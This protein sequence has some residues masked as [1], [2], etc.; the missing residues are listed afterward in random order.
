MKKFG[1]VLGGLITLFGLGIILT[2]LR[3]YFIIGSIV[4]FVLIINGI[5]T[6]VGGLKSKSRSKSISG[7]V[8]TAIA[9]FLLFTE[10]QQTLTE[11]F[12]IY[13]VAGGIMLTGLIETV[14]GLILLKKKENGLTTFLMGVGSL[15][16]GLAGIIFKET[17]AMV[18]G[19]VVGYHIVRFGLN[20]FT[21]ARD[22]D[23]PQVIDLKEQVIKRD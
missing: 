12:I 16:V 20:I 23:K 6:L 21:F 19:A 10:M 8:T 3:T 5:S 14:I 22:Y 4:G 15:G 18:I 7:I 11:N 17:T 1:M 13:L 9:L 2:P